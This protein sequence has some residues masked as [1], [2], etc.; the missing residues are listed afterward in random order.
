MA[1]CSCS[2]VDESMIEEQTESFSEKDTISFKINLDNSIVTRI[3]DEPE[4]QVLSDYFGYNKSLEEWQ[5]V[6]INLKYLCNPSAMLKAVIYDIEHDNTYTLFPIEHQKYHRIEEFWKA[7]DDSRTFEFSI[8][9][10]LDKTKLK[11]NVGLIQMPYYGHTTNFYQRTSLNQ[12]ENITMSGAREFKDSIKTRFGHSGVFNINNSGNQYKD[13][14]YISEPSISYYKSK[15][16]F[17][18]DGNLTEN[19]NLERL[20]SCIMVLTDEFNEYDPKFEV[21]LTNRVIGTGPGDLQHFDIWGLTTLDWK[22]NRRIF[23]YISPFTIEDE[24][25]HSPCVKED[26]LDFRSYDISII[27]ENSKRQ[28][29]LIDSKY[30]IPTSSAIMNAPQCATDIRNL[31]MPL[32]FRLNWHWIKHAPSDRIFKVVASRMITMPYGRP[33]TLETRIPGADTHFDGDETDKEI[34]YLVCNVFTIART[35]EFWVENPYANKWYRFVYEIPEGGLKPNCLYIIRNK[36]GTKLFKEW[37][38]DN[39]TTR[40]GD[41]DYVIDKSCFDIEE[42]QL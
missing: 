15:D 17:D 1:V 25:N 38:E 6:N 7:P 28:Y 29:N 33:R 16:L 14:L 36:Q 12:F 35:R 5:N 20:S 27:N 32:D 19:I 4:P 30:T 42:I 18:T 11:I 13:A 10:S 37:D 40:A 34:K 31:D 23:E 9:K 21:K 2:A 22:S 39:A 3:S 24:I 26:S 41:A 8:P